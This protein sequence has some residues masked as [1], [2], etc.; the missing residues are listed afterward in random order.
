M[1][2]AR[3]HLK[4]VQDPVP[5]AHQSSFDHT[6]PL[7][8]T[9][10]TAVGST[11]PNVFDVRRDSGDGPITASKIWNLNP[12]VRAKPRF[13]F[14][15]R[16]ITSVSFA[17]VIDTR[18]PTLLVHVLRDRARILVP[19]L[20]RERLLAHAEDVDVSAVTPFAPHSVATCRLLGSPVVSG[21]LVAIW[22]AAVPRLRRC[23][24][25]S[26]FGL[27]S[28]LGS[29]G[30]RLLA[31]E[32]QV[33]RCAVPLLRIVLIADPVVRVEDI[34]MKPPA[35]SPFQSNF[36]RRSMKRLA[37]SQIAVPPAPRDLFR[38]SAATPR[39]YPWSRGRRTARSLRY[40]AAF[41]LDG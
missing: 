8:D 17:R 33:H 12:I 30:E 4:D 14:S 35:S 11:A 15:A 29:A 36:A 40:A 13:T 38:G 2:D 34:L 3:G 31:E 20:A 7:H 32:L 19:P 22:C 25:G 10:G 5:R 28:L 26:S 24:R 41:R 21:S 27:C 1:A 39:W 37:R 23:C 6:A 16:E 18:K 9:P